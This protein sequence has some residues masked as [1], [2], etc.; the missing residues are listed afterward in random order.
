MGEGETKTK[1]QGL[2]RFQL[3]TGTWLYY[4]GRRRSEMSSLCVVCITSD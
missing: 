4:K 1:G 3:F 2:A